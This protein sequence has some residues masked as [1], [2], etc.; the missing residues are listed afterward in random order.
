MGNISLK[1]AI[2]TSFNN[3][4][5]N[6]QLVLVPLNKKSISNTKD[7]DIAIIGIDIYYTTCHLIKAQVFAIFL[8][9]LQ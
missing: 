6:K 7:V 1:T 2:I 8:K 5:K 4:N 9:N 3:S